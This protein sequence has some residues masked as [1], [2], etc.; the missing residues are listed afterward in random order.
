MAHRSVTHLDYRLFEL[1]HFVA[2]VPGFINLPSLNPTTSLRNA[3]LPVEFVLYS[4]AVGYSIFPASV[5]S[6][7]YP[8][9]K[10]LSFE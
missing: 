3:N 4:W 7:P 5:R 9:V 8:F 10:I 6:L 2:V 1:P